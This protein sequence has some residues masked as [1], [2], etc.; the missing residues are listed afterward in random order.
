MTFKHIIFD[1]DGVLIDSENISMRVDQEILAEHG[2][3]LSLED[4]H[5]RF[6]GTTLD[7]MI[8]ELEAEHKVHLP[9][10]LHDRKEVKMFEAY[11]NSL[12]PVAGVIDALNA[13][14]IPKSI[15]TNGPR[16]RCLEAL[17][18]V[19]L[20]DHFPAVTTYEDVKLGKPQPDVYLLASK[21]AGVAA[22][23]CIVVEDSTTGTRA[24]VAAGC[25]TL[26]FTGTHAHEKGYGERLLGL[27]AKQTFHDMAELPGIIAALT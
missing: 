27:G 10:N 5:S 19:G 18:I 24:G 25:Y 12:Q 23:N 6:V 11:R 2:I 26:G 7:D 15:G 16:L 4:L 17:R 1:C 21:R 8:A 13:I 20:F 9:Q 22:E 14:K 3:R